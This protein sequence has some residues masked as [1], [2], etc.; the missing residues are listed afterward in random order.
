MKKRLL[1]AALAL[2]MVLTLLPVSVFAESLTT[3]A[4]GDGT[5]TVTYIQ[6]EDGKNYTNG[7]GWYVTVMDPSKPGTILGYQLVNSGLSVG[8]KYYSSETN[9]NDGL[10]IYTNAA[11]DT[12]RGNL[13]AIGSTGS[14]S[15]AK[16]TSLTVDV[17]YGTVNIGS[18]PELTS[19]TIVDSRYSTDR[20]TVPTGTAALDTVATKLPKLTNLTASNCILTGTITMKSK[21]AQGGPQTHTVNLTNVNA[22]GASITLN[23]MATNTA[24]A[25]ATSGAVPDV[26]QNL[27]INNGLSVGAVNVSGNGSQV[28]LH[29]VTNTAGVTLNGSNSQLQVTG[30]SQLGTVTL[31]GVPNS[32]TSNDVALAP[33]IVN[34][35]S[36][37]SVGKISLTGA[38]EKCTQTQQVTI[39]GT[40]NGDV[41]LHNATVTM[42]SG[43]IAGALTLT[44]TGNVTLSGDRGSIK[45][46]VTLN[47]GVDAN[48]PST[49]DLSRG[50][51][52]TVGPLAVSGTNS[53]PATC[54]F[55]IPDVPSNTLTRIGAN[56][57]QH[58]IE[59]GTWLSAVS[60]DALATRLIYQVKAGGKFTYYDQDELADAILKQANV[61]ANKLTMVG[62]TGGTQKVLFKSGNITWG[63][64][65][66]APDTIIPKMPS[67]MNTVM[68]P[69]WTDG[70]LN[71]KAGEQYSTPTNSATT[72][73]VLNAGGGGAAT[74]D[75]TTITKAS[76]KDSSGGSMADYIRAEI[77]NNVITLTGA[78]P[79]G[80]TKFT[81]VLE[82]DA[83]KGQGNADPSD[84]PA[85]TGKERTV[86]LEVGMN[87]VPGAT[88][89]LTFA[90]T[91]STDLL[92]QDSEKSGV[93]QDGVN[94][95]KM[96]NGTRYT[97]DGSGLTV[98]TNTIKV[99]SMDAGVTYPGK[100]Q[101]GPTGAKKNSY[102]EVT[103]SAPGY[104]ATNAL[105]QQ[106]I[107][108]VV[109]TT[110]GS[111][112][113]FNWW[114]S[115]EI[116]RAVNAALAT[117]TER[118]V[119]NYISAAQR[120]AWSDNNSTGW[121]SGSAARTDYTD[122]VWLVPYLQVNVTS[123]KPNTG[124]SNGSLTATLTPMWRVEV[125]PD[126]ASPA[127]YQVK[128]NAQGLNQNG[129]YIA[130]TGTALTGISGDLTDAGSN[131]VWLNSFATGLT[132]VSWAHQ[133]GV[134][135]YAKSGNNFKITHAGQNNGLGTITIDSIAPMITKYA[136]QS[137]GTPTG[138]PN[139]YFS[140]L[141][142]AAADAA[143]NEH[144]VVNKDYAGSTTFNMT[145]KPRTI[146][147]QSN[148]KN[149]VVANATGGIAQVDP[150]GTLYTIRL[151]RDVT[152]NPVTTSRVTI[153]SATGG[154]ASVN[155]T[156]PA[157]G[158]T[159]TITLSASAGYAPSGVTVRDASGNA[160]SVSGS[161]STYTFTMPSTSV[162]V[163]PSFTRT[164]VVTNPTVSVSNALTGAGSAATSAGSSQVA[165]GTQ[166]TVTT[167]PGAGQ[168]TMGLSVT[169]ATAIRTGVNTFTFTVPSG[170]S[171][172][173]VTPSF[174]ANN[175][176]IFADVWSSSYYSK[177]V[178]WAVNKNPQVT[179]GSDTYSFS[180]D[181]VCNRAQMVTFLWRAAGR[182]SVAGI[183][184]PFVDVSA[185]QT[186]G[187]YY[188]AILWAVSQ[189]I[190][191]GTD[192][193]HFSPYATV[194]RGQAVTFLYRYEKSPA[195]NTNSGFYDVSSREYYARPVSWA[196]AKGV[197][198]GTST[199][200]FSP[201]DPVTRAQAVTFLYRDVTGDIA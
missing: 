73:V 62:Q 145:G 121:N 60:K 53:N 156:N 77:R 80:Q 151:N 49:F 133:D 120:Q 141:E 118:D 83:V 61:D 69:Q 65:T 67:Q 94:G 42:N 59:G 193:T 57:T 26:P 102:V 119:T 137:S 197:T 55:V 96:R 160:V 12:L 186:P 38:S 2:A 1:S 30:G 179:N 153:N 187:D 45:G 58:T 201:N 36:G 40:V 116:K 182:P 14:I 7:P 139:A 47:H 4:K 149:L 162:T 21:N 146:T 79:A 23:G 31:Q 166:V 11:H 164:Q 54:K 64:L 189:G 86:I 17:A 20:K 88:N 190:T 125:W 129:V 177:A 84:N 111:I 76:V 167:T 147:I 188:S 161:G 155:N 199:T 150:Q 191:D 148:G 75:V 132:G 114:Q 85:S 159:V 27:T 128:A 81:L 143:N 24:A 170:Y 6:K 5:E 46:G 52:C 171:T 181:D 113:Q 90:N 112:A 185:T 98:R 35:E 100:T 195:A 44:G 3:G 29:A 194:T 130:K 135:D 9:G 138:S 16:A 48:Q 68:T 37:S 101:V 140:S 124:S 89:N 168:R 176:T 109:G 56:Y 18:C 126:S 134:Y 25:Y 158:S 13:I 41:T 74:G 93:T 152:G 39:N 198:K 115:P 183:A 110:D 95:I 154:T 106:V 178:S 99:A 32:R 192:S 105:R 72:Q 87:F 184:N 127:K 123:Y 144:I 173:T 34:V 108:A 142:A 107:D 71:P 196:N 10:G 163:T 103:V 165:P 169:G 131:G 66:A 43:N 28:Q 33:P 63:V 200:M 92:D 175:N 19:L 97:L 157:T 78:V 22:S 122:E 180:P 15:L 8:N 117:V 91:G 174:D 104:T 51:N 172:V 70:V 50:T 82:T 136:G